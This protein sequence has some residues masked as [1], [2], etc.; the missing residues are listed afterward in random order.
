MRIL[1][2]RLCRSR[3]SLIEHDRR[4]HQ[5]SSQAPNELSTSSTLPGAG[6]LGRP[7][8]GGV[9]WYNAARRAETGLFACSLAPTGERQATHY[10]TDADPFTP[11]EQHVAKQ[12]APANEIDDLLR[13]AAEE[14]RRLLKRERRAEKRVA[15]LRE[16][17]TEAQERLV[18]AQDRVAR[19]TKSLA[20]AEQDLG[21][22]REARAS[23]PRSDSAGPDQL[24]DP[25]GNLPAP[26]GPQAPVPAPSPR[27]SD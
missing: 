4:S 19:R 16:E 2:P 6:D 27:S 3:F 21:E 10:R 22:H 7:R 26:D 1:T 9:D 18:E 11:G 17:V 15:T 23:G 24:P 8:P 12:K 20:E 13:R 25:P 5:L 14:E